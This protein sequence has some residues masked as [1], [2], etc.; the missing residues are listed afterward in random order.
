M[1]L[2]KTLSRTTAAI[3]L[4]DSWLKSLREMSDFYM[5]SY[6]MALHGEAKVSAEAA[7]GF[8][9]PVYLTDAV[10]AVYTH[11]HIISYHIYIDN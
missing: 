7:P 9:N 5:M 2:E 11:V 10:Q 6:V 1:Q 4:N 3:S 8:Q